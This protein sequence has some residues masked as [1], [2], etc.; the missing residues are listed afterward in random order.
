M[1]QMAQTYPCKIGTMPSL[2]VLCRNQKI[3]VGKTISVRDRKRGSKSF[4]VVVRLVRDDGWFL[5][6]RS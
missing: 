1:K 2:V 4:N 3:E 5:A 6:D